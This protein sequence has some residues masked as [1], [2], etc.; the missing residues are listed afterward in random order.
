M[1][2][3]KTS[4]ERMSLTQIPLQRW[5]WALIAAAICL[6]AFNF[7]SRLATIRRMSQD[8]AR[9]AES[10]AA[11]EARQANLNA[12][13]GYV[14]G[15][16]YVE[17]WARVEARMIKPHEVLVVPVAPSRPSAASF[18]VA[19]PRAPATIMEEWWSLFFGAT[20]STP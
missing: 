8:E 14:A 11:E 18:P 3:K 13:R 7:N 1:T 16:G 12:L 9:L 17:H 15:D 6:L 2:A 5:T 10:V 20:P 4:T 19:P